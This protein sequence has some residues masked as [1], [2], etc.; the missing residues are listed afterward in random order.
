MKQN[1][2]G[3]GKWRVFPALFTHILLYSL[4]SSALGIFIPLYLL[5]IG[6][7]YS[8]VMFYLL[9]QWGVF[10]L[11]TPIQ[12]KVM[13]KLGYV[14]S[15]L[16][17]IG[18]YCCLIL[19]LNAMNDMASIRALVYGIAVLFGFFGGMYALSISSYFSMGI[20]K[21]NSQGSTG[22]F[23]FVS[24]SA[25]IAGLLFGGIISQFSYGLLFVI[26][27]MLLLLSLVPLRG[28]SGE[29]GN[30]RA[31]AVLGDSIKKEKNEFLV[32]VPYGLLSIIPFAILPLFL[33]FR[34]FGRVSIGSALASIVLIEVIISFFYGRISSRVKPT[35]IFKGGA[36]F[37]GI[38]FLALFFASTPLM[39]W[40]VMLSYGLANILFMLPYESH[41]YKR[42][43]LKKMPL[44]F[45]IFK[46]FSLGIGRC[47]LFALLLVGADISMSF[48]LGSAMAFSFVLFSKIKI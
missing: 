6:M 25:G 19:L 35:W 41:L 33:H 31:K 22:K 24:K 36:F 2:L 43:S 42:A 29:C 13:A 4:A 37:L 5:S 17:W 30:P 14:K 15:I 1:G 21:K 3:N 38:I 26:C 9:I 40:A 11:T 7:G 34:E 20:T 8:K 18:V 27:F 10:G 12:A 48:L 46:E 44:E 28:I 32:L 16:L 45:F 47:I 23:F 39:V